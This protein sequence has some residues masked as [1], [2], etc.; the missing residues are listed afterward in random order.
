VNKPLLLAA[1]VA[2]VLAAAAKRRHA[3]ADAAQLWREA[4]ADASR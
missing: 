2:A 3:Q 4:T 1:A